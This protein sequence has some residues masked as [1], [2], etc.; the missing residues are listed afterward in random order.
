MKGGDCDGRCGVS[1]T[2][3]VFCPLPFSPTLGLRHNTMESH[4]PILNLVA[5]GVTCLHFT[6]FVS[7]RGR[8]V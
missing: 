2:L 1:C 5:F 4:P 7:L 6:D 3:K 8:M